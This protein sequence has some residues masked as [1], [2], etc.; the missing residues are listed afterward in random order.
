MGHAPQRSWKTEPQAPGPGTGV[1]ETA[2][3]EGKFLLGSG[4]T[5]LPQEPQRRASSRLA[6]PL[7][8]HF[9]SLLCIFLRS[10]EN[11]H[12]FCLTVKA[13]QLPE[14]P[15]EASHPQ[16][17][18]LG[19]LFPPVCSGELVGVYLFKG[20]AHTCAQPPR[21]AGM[22]GIV[23]TC[24]ERTASREP[25]GP[26]QLPA[27]TAHPCP[28][29]PEMVGGEWERPWSFEPETGCRCQPHPS[30]FPTN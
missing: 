16:P 15:S 30:S 28:P 20:T 2:K 13:R 1:L 21:R 4:T 25:R 14:K 3:R 7:R 23:Q 10:E 6:F 19:S 18:A 24:L 22:G 9:S 8:L 29:H 12:Q 26:G 5:V 11:H 27:L 17:P